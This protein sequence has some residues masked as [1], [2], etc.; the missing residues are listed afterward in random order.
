IATQITDFQCKVYA[1]Y[2]KVRTAITKLVL[3]NEHVAF[4]KKLLQEELVTL[5]VTW[6]VTILGHWR[7]DLNFPMHLMSITI[8]LKPAEDSCTL[9]AINVVNI[10]PNHPEIKTTKAH[11]KGYLIPD[12]AVTTNLPIGDNHDMKQW[13]CREPTRSE[14]QRRKSWLN[15]PW[16][17]CEQPLKNCSTRRQRP[18]KLN[19]GLRKSERRWRR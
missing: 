12:S 5:T 11:K 6:S 19:E 15:K 16:K 18:S 9:Q 13:W 2:W 8:K 14:R 1:R 10:L 3:D 4:N 17:L 7:A